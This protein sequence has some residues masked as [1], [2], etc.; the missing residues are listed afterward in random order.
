MKKLF[1]IYSLISLIGCNS[2]SKPAEEIRIVK[3]DTAKILSDSPDISDFPG[4]VLAGSESNISFRI[5]G[6]L[7]KLHVSEG[8]YV[9]EGALLASMDDRDYI[10]QLKATQAEYN[11]IEAEA[12]RIIE[13]YKTNSVTPNDYDKAVFGLQQISAKL[14]AHKNALAD[15]RLKAPY[16]GYIQTIYF[17]K[18]ETISAGMP[19]FSMISTA[20]PEIE[21]NIPTDNFIKRGNYVSATASLHAYP[22]HKFRLELIGINQKANLNQLY[23]TRFKIADELKPAPG[24][25]AIVSIEY[26]SNNSSLC[27]IPFSAINENQVW[28]IS[29]DSVSRR[30]IKCIEV[31]TDGTA[32]VEGLKNGE[33][34]VSAGIHSLCNGQKVKVQ[35]ARSNSNIGGLL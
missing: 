7:A 30:K 31:H 4:R 24:M 16:S 23:K 25:T 3:C 14:E 35:P 33:L 19:V 12:N 8:Q 6:Q 21:I 5:S 11:Q 2:G 9:Q 26:S 28:V 17:D 34:V 10:I 27:K 32:V 13:L 1:L 22:G 29:G 20:S 18:G 15:T